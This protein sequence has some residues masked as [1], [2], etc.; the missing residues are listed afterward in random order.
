MRCGLDKAAWEG[1]GW[2]KCHDLTQAEPLRDRNGDVIIA[3]LPFDLAR[4]HALY[5]A[6]FGQAEDLIKGKSLIVVPSGP[7][8]QLPFQVLLTQPPASGDVKS[9]AWLIRDHALTVLPAVSSLKALRRVSRPSAAKKTMIGFGNPLLEGDPAD[10]DDQRRAQDA[11]D[12][13]RCPVPHLVAANERSVR[14]VAP[15][16]TRGGLASVAQIRFQAPLPETAQELCGVA[17][18]VDA[19]LD[20]IYLGARAT[21]HDVKEL[22]RTGQLA[23]YRIV[24][25][26]T[27]G[28]LSGQ[29]EGNSEPGLLLTPPAEASEE[30]DGYLTASEIAAL[31]LDAD[32]VILSA[33]NTAGRR[34]ARRRGAIGPRPRLH[35][36]PGPRAARLAL[37]GCLRCN[38]EAH[39]GRHA[40]A[41]GG[42][43]NRPRGGHAAI[44]AGTHRSWRAARGASGLLG[45]VRAGGRGCC[46]AVMI[47]GNAPHPVLLPTGEG[48]QAQRLQQRSLSQRERERGVACGVLP[49][50]RKQHAGKYIPVQF[51]SAGA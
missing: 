36:C 5:R 44:H 32:W 47:Y 38:R 43:G 41:R 2:L 12:F 51:R 27:H 33:C 18:D 28:A 17:R 22:S 48:T 9:A 8:T 42:Q 6:L 46:G 15:L 29:I 19:D 23:Q 3:T 31:K 13:K 11:R 24:H 1:G 39:R 45:A 49:Y 37:G 16:A 40:P 7:L 34:R 14:G 21:E 30:D 25:F 20:G 4:A 35:L 26:A 50:P 10:A